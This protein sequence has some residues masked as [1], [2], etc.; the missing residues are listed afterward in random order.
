VEEKKKDKCLE[1]GLTNLFGQ[2]PE[3]NISESEGHTFSVANP[4]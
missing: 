1:Q 3:V 2:G 4:E